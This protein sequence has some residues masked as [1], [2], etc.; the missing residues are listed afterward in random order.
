MPRARKV[1]A[2]LAA[3]VVASV[4][5]ACGRREVSPAVTGPTGPTTTVPTGTDNGSLR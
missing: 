2:A 1:A 4:L 5:A 3:L